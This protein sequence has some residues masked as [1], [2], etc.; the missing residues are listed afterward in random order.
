MNNYWNEDA[1]AQQG[2]HFTFRYAV[3]SDRRSSSVVSTY[4]SL[5]SRSPLLAL[6]HEHKEWKQTLPVEGAGF[7]ESSPPGVV[8]LTIRPA[9]DHQGYMVRVHNTSDQDVT[10]HLH[11]TYTDINGAYLSSLLGNKIASVSSTAHD[12]AFPLRRF[13]VRTV[14]VHVLHDPH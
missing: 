14:M 2:G 9:L 1:P 5:E 10:A 3:T 13:D 11:F 7:V 12:V 8:V 6:R 4:L